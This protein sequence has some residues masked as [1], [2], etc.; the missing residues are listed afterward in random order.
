MNIL[1]KIVYGTFAISIIYLLYR[2]GLISLILNCIK[3]A[4]FNLSNQCCPNICIKN[5]VNVSPS[6]VPLKVR[7]SKAP[8]IEEERIK[9]KRHKGITHLED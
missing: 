7:Y 3:N 1:N 8:E 2:I 5:K 6:N 9:I 4:I